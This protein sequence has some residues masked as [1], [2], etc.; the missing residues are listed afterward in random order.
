MARITYCTTM[1]WIVNENTMAD[2]CM[3]I[4]CIRTSRSLVSALYFLLLFY[5]NNLYI[6]KHFIMA[7]LHLII[8]RIKYDVGITVITMII[9]GITCTRY[10]TDHI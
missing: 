3:S 9:V 7:R 1:A 10:G 8:A 2:I 5:V 4:D 6:Y